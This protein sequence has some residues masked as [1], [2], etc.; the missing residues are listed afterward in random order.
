MENQLFRESINFSWPAVPCYN[1][2]GWM[3]QLTH[4]LSSRSS[5]AMPLPA[6]LKRVGQQ[7]VNL[8][9]RRVFHNFYIQMTT[10]S[11]YILKICMPTTYRL[12]RPWMTSD[13]QIILW[14]WCRRFHTPKFYRDVYVSYMR[15]G[16]YQFGVKCIKPLSFAIQ[17]KAFM[18]K[19]S[20]KTCWK[21]WFKIFWKHF[22]IACALLFEQLHSP[23]N[24]FCK[25]SF[26]GGRSKWNY[27]GLLS[28]EW[29]RSFMVIFRLR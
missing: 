23:R 4:V 7:E 8:L 26:L 22:W 17:I 25:F 12:Y 24:D 29:K 5:G 10:N 15:A 9:I 6:R 11:S 14:T 20:Y 28:H 1:A 13:N 16:W 21:L 27:L 18:Q 2:P 19:R 3:A